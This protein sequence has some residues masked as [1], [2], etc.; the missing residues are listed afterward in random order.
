M[1]IENAPLFKELMNQVSGEVVPHHQPRNGHY[2]VTCQR[3]TQL[4]Q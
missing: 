4:E 2:I 1:F 3:I